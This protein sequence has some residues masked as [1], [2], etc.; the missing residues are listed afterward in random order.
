MEE[1]QSLPL[2]Q[3]IFMTVNDLVLALYVWKEEGLPEG[4]FR[5]CRSFD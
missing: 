1:E 5:A 2:E 4:A 3:T